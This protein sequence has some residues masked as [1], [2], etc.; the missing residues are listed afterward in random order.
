[1]DTP[2]EAERY[3]NALSQGA[4]ITMPLSQTFW[5]IRFGMLV[6]RFGVSWMV[7][8]EAKG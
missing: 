5:A 7:N 4:T 8:C 1:M 6:D 3:F 2:D